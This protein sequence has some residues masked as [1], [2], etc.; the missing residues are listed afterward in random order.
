MCSTKKNLEN[1]WNVNVRW[2]YKKN[3]YNE[4]NLTKTM[5]FSPSIELK[6]RDPMNSC[7]STCVRM[8]N[9][10]EK[11]KYLTCVV[12]SRIFYCCC[13]YGCCCI[14]IMVLQSVP[15]E[16]CYWQYFS[17]SLC[18]RNRVIFNIKTVHLKRTVPKSIVVEVPS[19][20]NFTRKHNVSKI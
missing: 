15:W 9:E 20:Y 8:R 18:V 12:K 11:S 17:S 5:L 2:S 1:I 7:N 16:A 4:G 19:E 3:M 6:D 10:M 14:D 13:C